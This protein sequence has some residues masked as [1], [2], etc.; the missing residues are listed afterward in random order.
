MPRTYQ[1]G[2]VDTDRRTRSIGEQQQASPI[3]ESKLADPFD[4]GH[5]RRRSGHGRL[6]ADNA[7]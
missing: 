4:R 2:H 5:E 1:D 3:V 6:I 7:A